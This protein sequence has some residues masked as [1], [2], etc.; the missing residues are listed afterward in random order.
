[1]LK[2]LLTALAC[3]ALL[4]VAALPA[5]AQDSPKKDDPEKVIG[6][7]I[8]L[9][10][11]VHQIK[12]DEKGRLLSC[13][14][15]G[16]ATIHTVLGVEQGTEVARQQAQLAAKAEFR[17]WLQSTV[18]VREGA[19]SEITVSVE[20]S[21]ENDQKVLREGGKVIDRTTRRYELVAEGLVRGLQLLGV[22]VR[23]KE[24]TYSVVYSFRTEVAEAVKK[25]DSDH[26][27]PFKKEDGKKPD[28]PN[29]PGTGKKPAEKKIEEKRVVS[30]DVGKFTD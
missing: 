20:G 19:E 25:V 22:D 10:P 7:I 24:M 13:V 12:T 9:G 3:A 27:V 2:R 29:K 23:D 1:M 11:G 26:E 17:K 18:S 16:R 14:V 21:K 8:E 28:E 6:K 15:V 5:N 4:A 30:D